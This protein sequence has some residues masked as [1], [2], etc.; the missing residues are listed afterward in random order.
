MGF[1][2]SVDESLERRE[3]T[4]AD[5]IS[6]TGSDDD[7]LVDL[8]GVSSSACLVFEGMGGR[9][10]GKALAFE[11]G[12]VQPWECESWPFSKGYVISR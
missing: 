1:D 3:S 9:E 8:V 7:S 12:K 11:V 5:D 2:V 10:S 4:G 6:W